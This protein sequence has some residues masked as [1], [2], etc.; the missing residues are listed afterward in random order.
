M[1]KISSAEIPGRPTDPEVKLNEVIPRWQPLAGKPFAGKYPASPV[2]S[3]IDSDSPVLLTLPKIIYAVVGME[4]R[5][6]FLNLVF[7]DN[8]QALRFELI[9]SVGKS[10][11]DRWTFTPD[12]PGNYALKIAVFDSDGQCVGNADTII[13]VA[14]ADA[15]NGHRA[16]ILTVGD[17]IFADGG[18]VNKHQILLKASGHDCIRMMGSHSGCG[19]PLTPDGIA[20]EAYG[21]WKWQCFIDRHN[22][23][24]NYNSESKFTR[25]VDG[26]NE[27][28]LQEYLDKY[29]DGQAPDAVIFALGCNDIALAEPDNLQQLIENSFA[30][31]KKLILEFQQIM[32]DTLIGITLLPPPNISESAFEQNYHGEITQKQ[33]SCNQFN[34]MRQT[35]LELQDDSTVSLIPV[36]A[37]IDEN[38]AYPADNALHPNDFGKQ[39]FAETLFAWLKNMMFNC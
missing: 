11:P 18:I 30:A 19:A 33:Y 12:A 17:S 28:I 34:Y 37:A 9:S 22:G 38:M 7:A 2:V 5:I 13:R 25:V 4:T 26:K 29:N 21:G 20:V 1:S 24:G 31:R 8:K 27:F 35:L 16:V 14:P 36:Y 32:P 15:G 10:Y 39:Q 6:C 3:N 23:N